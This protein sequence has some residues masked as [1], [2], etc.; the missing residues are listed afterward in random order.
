MLRL[1][2]SVGLRYVM[3]S[4]TER[5]PSYEQS[6]GT[7]SSDQTTL[8]PLQTVQIAVRSVVPE[9]EAPEAP[10]EVFKWIRL[11]FA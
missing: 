2:Y 9:G 10:A 6:W 8:E 1:H 4:G 11:N 3:S 5:M 7:S